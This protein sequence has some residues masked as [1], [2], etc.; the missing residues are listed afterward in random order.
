MLEQTPLVENSDDKVVP[1][2]PLDPNAEKIFNPL[3]NQPTR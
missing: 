1:E 2:P 3:T